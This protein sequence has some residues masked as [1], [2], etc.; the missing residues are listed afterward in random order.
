ME[1]SVSGHQS[2]RV[3]VIRVSGYQDY[4]GLENWRIGEWNPDYD[5]RGQAIL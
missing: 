5:I 2:I 3:E 4:S 1:N